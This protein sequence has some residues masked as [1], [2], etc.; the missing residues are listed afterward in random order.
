MSGAAQKEWKKKLET[1]QDDL[2]KIENQRDEL[3]VKVDLLEKNLEDSQTKEAEL[4]VR[5]FV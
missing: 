2:F 3:Q 5:L 4:Q 1:M